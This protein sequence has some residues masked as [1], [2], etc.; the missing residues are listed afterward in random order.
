MKNF[1]QTSFLLTVGILQCLP[2]SAAVRQRYFEHDSKDSKSGVESIV[3]WPRGANVKLS[4]HQFSSTLASSS[5]LNFSSAQSLIGQSVQ[6]WTDGIRGA[7][8]LLTLDLDS[9]VPYALNSGCEAVGNSSTSAGDL[10]NNFLFTSKLNTSCAIKVPEGSGVIGLTKVRYGS[11]DGLI[12][13]ADIQFDDTEFLFTASGN[14]DLESDIV[15]LRDVVV[16]EFGHFLGLDHTPVR[17]ASMI[18]SIAED[19][20]TPKDEDFSGLFALYPPT[21]LTTNFS[22]LQGSL[23]DADNKAVFGGMI[24][25]I[26]PRTMSVVASEISDVNGRF[27]F[28]AVPKGSY[29]VYSNSYTPYGGNIH[30]YYSGD[31]EGDGTYV[32]KSSSNGTETTYCYN[33]SC[34]VMSRSLKYGPLSKALSGAGAQGGLAMKVVNIDGTQ[35]N[36]FLNL[37]AT[38]VDP[39]MDLVTGTVGTPGSALFLDEPRWAKLSASKIALNGAGTINS[40]F[41]SFSAPASGSITVKAMSLRIFARLQ[42]SLALFTNSGTSVSCSGGTSTVL[43]ASDPTLICSGLSSGSTYHLR[44]SGVGVSC[45]DI[46]GN[47]FGSDSESCENSSIGEDAS[48]DIAYYILNVFE[49]GTS[50]DENYGDADVFSADNLADTTWNSLPECSAFSATLSQ[51]SDTGACCASLGGRGPNKPHGPSS[52][53]LG[54]LL[55]PLTAFLVFWTFRERKRIRGK[56]ISKACSL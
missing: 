28:C 56:Q 42:L 35:E 2:L 53:L 24:F 6:K 52:F 32:L 33:P 50:L 43:T 5:S 46:P 1:L 19:L 8:P 20:Q 17:E 41:Y 18:F 55:N 13:E 10:V 16:H 45:R 15:N 11:K 14:N 37:S 9:G 48:T 49:S 51:G 12:T 38:A 39:S 40:D 22:T 25:L 34:E 23:R 29:I 31:A 26:N 54:I 30:A 7:L 21:N 4:M 27:K 3:H 36:L 47:Y 44:V